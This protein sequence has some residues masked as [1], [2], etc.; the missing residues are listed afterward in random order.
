VERIEA[1][2]PTETQ[3]VTPRPAKNYGKPLLAMA[4][5]PGWMVFLAD[6]L[7]NQRYPWM[8]RIEPRNRYGS[9]PMRVNAVRIG[10]LALVTLAT[11]TFT[12][13]GMVVKADSPARHTLFAS[14][15]DGCISFLYT[16]LSHPEGGYEVDVAPLAYRYPGRLSADCQTIALGTARAILTSL[17]EEKELNDNLERPCDALAL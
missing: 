12:K 3:A 11:E 6:P 8:P 17:W 14:I 7:L 13:I 15:T 2:L 10:K 4:K 5:L 1:W 16:A 9:V